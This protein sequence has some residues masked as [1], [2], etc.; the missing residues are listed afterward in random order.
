KANGSDFF[1]NLGHQIS[2]KPLPATLIGAGIAWF[3]MANGSSSKSSAS[4][5]RANGNGQNWGDKSWSDSASELADSAY[6]TGSEWSDKAGS[7]MRSAK[8]TAKSAA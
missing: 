6:E 1:R 7:A 2:E 8:D 3:I 4:R 5:M